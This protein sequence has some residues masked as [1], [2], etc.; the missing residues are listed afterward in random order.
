MSSVRVVLECRRLTT[1][2][3]QCIPE[4]SDDFDHRS[5]PH[6]PEADAWLIAAPSNNTVG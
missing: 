1:G 2:A 6:A 3:V 5:T 4:L